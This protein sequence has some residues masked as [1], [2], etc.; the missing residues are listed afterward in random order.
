MLICYQNLYNCKGGKAKT[1]SLL[2]C[3]D[4]PS[5]HFLLLVWVWVLGTTVKDTQSSLSPHRK[6][7]DKASPVK[8]EMF[9][10][11]ELR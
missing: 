7:M 6:R 4:L 10:Q 8:I 9:Y 1:S 11:K 2:R 3:F 5:I